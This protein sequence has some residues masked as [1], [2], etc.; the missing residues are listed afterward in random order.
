M[1]DV[2]ASPVYSAADALR[3]QGPATARR[4]LLAA[5]Q[6]TLEL[7]RAYQAALGPTL[8]V[9]QRATLNP[10]LWELGH[11]AWFQEY[12]LARNARRDE[13]AALTSQERAPS[14]LAS[15]DRLYDSSHVPHATRWSLPLP[16][17][18]ATH[19]Y[20]A[21]SLE[22]TLAL[23]D[24]LPADAGD[25]ALYF[26]RL[27]ALHEEMHAEAGTYMA[28]ALGIEVPDG[29]LRPVRTREDATIAVPAQVF[30]LGW[31]GRGFAF[32]NELHAHDV[33]LDMFE[34]D[35]RAVTWGRFLP[36]M[37]AGGY[38]DARW[39]DEPG[40]KWLSQVEGAAR[41]RRIRTLATDP[42]AA[43]VHLT[44]HEARAWCRWAG[45]RLP[46]EAEWEC[47]ALT[48]PGLAWGEVWE[49]TASPFAPYP[50]FEPHPYRD[51]SAPWF[52]TR[53][54]LRG[55][56]P[57]TATTLAHPRY[58]NFFEPHRD[59]VFGGFRSCAAGPGAAAV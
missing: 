52:H 41:E 37:E 53:V 26:F 16:D 12:W 56:C 7:A 20:L 36:F 44:A 59:D 13:G 11:I 14:L 1:D 54:V 35:A 28:R 8:P 45:R 46:T 25:D 18:R 31:S 49:W 55:A 48:A 51:Y 50:G 5:R 15:A 39:W 29:V 19:D 32:D 21:R 2:A 34:I 27:T 43:A 6:R 57:A 24:A 9:P 23:L 58:R 4:A 3:T 42:H 33:A 40:A 17:L 30:R 38:R 22:Q 47:A 10:P